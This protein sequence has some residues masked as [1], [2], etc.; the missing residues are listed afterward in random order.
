MATRDQP[1]PA[2][3]PRDNPPPAAGPDDSTEQTLARSREIREQG[4]R[5]IRAAREGVA[6][7]RRRSGLSATDSWP[8]ARDLAAGLVDVGEEIERSRQSRARLAALAGR[9]VQTEE[10]VARIHD[11]MAGRDSPRAAQ[12]RRAAEDARQAAQRAREIQR[13]AARSDPC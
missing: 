2:A 9:L 11:E 3:A 10:T 12:Y 1:P 7:W 8:V 6:A 13:K 5:Q 4:R